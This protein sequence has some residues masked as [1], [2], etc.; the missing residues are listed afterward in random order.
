MAELHAI[1]G[2]AALGL[3]VVLAIVAVVAAA[4]RPPSWLGYV[5][6]GALGVV[7]LQSVVGLLVLVGGGGP[8]DPTHLL[9]G[10]VATTLLLGAPILTGALEDRLRIRVL[11]G[12]AVVA[13]GIALR[14]LQT[15]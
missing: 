3:L 14:L 8:S 12:A 5:W 7:V 11:A 9:Y 10:V 13:A 15:G 2:R 6:L 4:T 1:A